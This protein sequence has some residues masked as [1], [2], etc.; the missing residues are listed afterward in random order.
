[1]RRLLHTWA[2]DAVAHAEALAAL[3]PTWGSKAHPIAGGWLVLSGAGMYVNR[4]MAA[5]L[6]ARL[7]A[8][9]IDLILERSAAC[10]VG[11][12]VE[13]TPATGRI[14]IDTLLAR[15]FTHATDRDVTALTRPIP[16][17][18]VEAPKEI[19]GRPV[20]SRADLQLWMDTAAVG[21]GHSSLSA[22]R[23]SDAFS[24][25]AHAVERDNMVLAFDSG[26]SDPIGCAT[27][28]IR[29]RLATLGG[30][31]T[32]PSQRRRGVQAALLH[33]RLEQAAE[34]NCDL[35]ATS[36]ATG[37]ASE[38]NL[39]RHGFRPEFVIKTYEAPRSA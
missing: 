16:G 24:L 18:P 1:M 3:D 2:L 15:G 34:R 8:S 4:A 25:A 29:D 12:A 5:G 17:H 26:H 7:S 23:A 9:D 28:T 20:A 11:A 32:I 10:G 21:W 30:M 33:H 39:I 27:T 37:G 19:V 22:R 6:D 14:T 36:A 38:R 13:V 31:S 35:A